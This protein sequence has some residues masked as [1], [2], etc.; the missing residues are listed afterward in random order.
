MKLTIT[1]ISVKDT[2]KNG[3]P[4]KIATGKLAG[5]PYWRVAFQAEETGEQW[6]SAFSFSQNDD[7]H[8][9]KVGDVIER[10]IEEIEKNGVKYFNVKMQS[11]SVSRKEFDEL[12]ARTEK[13]ERHLF[14][15]QNEEYPEEEIPF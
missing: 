12:K 8:A 14:N 4:Y 2:D 9:I 7:W 6:I 11:K 3:N 1:K 5:K 10:D 13:I 15:P